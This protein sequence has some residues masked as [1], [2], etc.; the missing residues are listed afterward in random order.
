M[1][2]YTRPGA[3]AR[4]PLEVDEVDPSLEKAVSWLSAERPRWRALLRRPGGPELLHAERA[5][6][7][8][9]GLG[10][11]GRAPLERPRGGADPRRRLRRSPLLLR[12]GPRT[13]HLPHRPLRHGL[14]P[15]H[16]RGLPGGRGPGARTGRPRHEGRA[17][18]RDLRAACAAGGGAPRPGG[19]ARHLRG[20][21][22][23]GLARVAADHGREGA[24]RVGGARARVGSRRGPHRHPEE[25]RRLAR[26]AGA[27][28]GRAR[29]RRPRE[30]EE[31]GAGR[32]PASWTGSRG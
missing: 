6:R 16:L 28:G 8:R 25:G 31:R 5:G 11:R 22:G 19:G 4:G 3:L 13:V 24:G 1:K 30:G 18:G 27:R 20:R 29:G 23:G 10:G 21:R 32:S 15:G 9:G 17:R 12:P 7:E 2:P 26:R 14:P